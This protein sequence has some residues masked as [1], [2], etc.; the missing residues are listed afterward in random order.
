VIFHKLFL[1]ANFV[2]SFPELR[3]AATHIFSLQNRLSSGAKV[4]FLVQTRENKIT[5]FVDACDKLND[6]FCGI[7][8]VFTGD[9]LAPR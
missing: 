6:V 8:S 4:I 9:T 2:I 7:K 3:L 5:N 1:K